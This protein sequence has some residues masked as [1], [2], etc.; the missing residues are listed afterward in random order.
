MLLLKDQELQQ[1]ADA[2]LWGVRQRRSEAR[3][4]LE[5][6]SALQELREARV[7]RRTAAGQSTSA[8]EIQT[9]T[10][11]ISKSNNILI[12]KCLLPIINNKL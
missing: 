5:L 6:L 8:I 12:V 11:V 4:Q 7:R 1:E 3:R 9:F 10:T 2:V